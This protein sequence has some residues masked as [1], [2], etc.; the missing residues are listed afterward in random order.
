MRRHRSP[1]PSSNPHTPVLTTIGLSVLHLARATSVVWT[2]PSA[3][4]VYASGDTI[5]GEWSAE[6]ETD[7]SWAEPAFSLCDASSEAQT[8]LEAKN[9]DS[10]GQDALDTG[11]NC[12]ASVYP[13]VQSDGGS[14]L[15]QVSL[16]NVTSPSQFVLRMQASSGKTACSPAFQLTPS[17]L[18]SSASSP[19]KIASAAPLGVSSSKIS[20]PTS[21]PNLSQ[22]TSSSS[23]DP[24]TD[25]NSALSTRPAPTAAYAVPLALVLTVLLAAGAL[26][27][28]ERRRLRV[29]RGREREALSRRPT[30]ED[31]HAGEFGSLRSGR[32]GLGVGM[33]DAGSSRASTP[34]AAAPASVAGSF[35]SGYAHARSSLEGKDT[36]NDA[37]SLY[38]VASVRRQ[39]GVRRSTRSSNPFGRRGRGRVSAR[40]FRSA[41]SPVPP[42]LGRMESE[43]WGWGWKAKEVEGKEENAG[44]EEDVLER[45]AGPS[46]VPPF[47]SSL[48]R[49]GRRHDAELLSPHSNE[50]Q[51]NSEYLSPHLDLDALSPV[52]LTPSPARPERLHVRRCAEVYQEAC[53]EKPLPRR[54][55]AARAVYEEVARKVGGWRGG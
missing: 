47:L 9:Q 18:L 3:G 10:D 34:T 22:N 26:C 4:D 20:S 52:P 54:P 14:C 19:A 28:R 43:G 12:G 49:G 15:I 5:V 29:E 21:Y 39:Q 30:M 37:A 44:V 45:Y 42:V 7:E 55:G 8:A 25:P 36:D 23:T 16:P 31:A 46:P 2:S 48:A 50:H 1:P 33:G 53:E 35:R 11:Q 6:P 40:E 27:V 38:S 32:W 51:H 17:A 13:D 41:V 24:L